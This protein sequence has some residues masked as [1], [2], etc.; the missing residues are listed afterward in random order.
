MA[1][2]PEIAARLDEQQFKWDRQNDLLQTE[3]SRLS[4]QMALSLQTVQADVAALQRR[5]EALERSPRPAAAPGCDSFPP[6]R[7]VL[8]APAFPGF[9]PPAPPRSADPLFSSAILGALP[10]ILAQFEGKRLALLWRATAQDFSAREFHAR[11]DGRAHT[12]TLVED[13]EGNVFGGFTPLAWESRAGEYE[14]RF[15]QDDSGK[16]FLFTVRSHGR[17]PPRVFPLLPAETH[18]AIYCS[19]TSG[20]EFGAGTTGYGDLAVRSNTGAMASSS[21]LGQSYQGAGNP[22]VLA[23]KE[24]FLVNKVEVFE[25]LG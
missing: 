16:G 3:V 7:P 2:I 15:K 12:L 23:G 13:S 9:D 20:P 5:L 10:P 21:N 22:A 1:T 24:Q 14:D 25:V 18:H 6:S 4:Q 11:C 17:L 8:P 19:V